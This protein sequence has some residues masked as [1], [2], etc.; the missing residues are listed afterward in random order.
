MLA[1]AACTE[2]QQKPGTG[3][4][5][6]ES[7]ARL[8]VSFEASV[9]PRRPAV[10]ARLPAEIQARVPKGKVAEAAGRKVL[11]LTVEKLG[12]AAPPILGRYERMGDDLVFTPAFPL[13]P[14][15]R[16]LASLFTGDREPIVTAY[17]VPAAPAAAPAEVVSIDPLV[18]EVPANLLRL[19]ANFSA[20]ML[21][22]EGFYEHVKLVDLSTG[23]EVK[24]AWR[25]IQLWSPDR[26]RL[27]L[28][29]HPGRVKRDITF[30]E[31]LGPVLHA[32]KEYELILGAALEDQNGKPLSGEFRKTFKVAE[33][34][35]RGPDPDQWKVQA[36]A[37][38]SRDPATIT[39]DEAMDAELLLREVSVLGP[40]GGPVEGELKLRDGAASVDFIPT[41]GWN[42]GPHQF[43]IA[44]ELEDLAGN[45]S[46]NPFD[47]PI[48][49]K[50]DRKPVTQLAF[51]VAG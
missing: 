10:A 49:W 33:S 43:A 24:M 23:D 15:Q 31:E 51:D 39:F 47:R 37:L 8:V 25:E 3:P 32:G 2:S 34:D 45:T 50:T 28:L 5:P 19:Y 48:D 13:E 6:V 14:G 12:P 46:T 38:G 18:E 41:K 17:E 27:T 44:R 11:V 42:A 29:I 4:V 26:T 1:L 22:G 36:P 40:D 21:G 35:D 16:Y 30:A 20:P 7:A 9:D